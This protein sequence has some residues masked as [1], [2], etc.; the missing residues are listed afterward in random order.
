MK[1][2]DLLQRSTIRKL[3]TLAKQK[4]RKGLLS[5]PLCVL[6]A[7]AERPLNLFETNF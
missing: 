4:S 7:E 3:N 6:S 5:I 2:V 1:T